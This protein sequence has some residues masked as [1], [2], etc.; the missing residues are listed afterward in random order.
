MKRPVIIGL[1][2]LAVLV[3]ALALNI[4]LNQREE[5]EAA[6][7]SPAV[8]AQPSAP[9]ASAPQAANSQAASPVPTPA[10]PQAPAAV[11]PAPAQQAQATQVPATQVPATQAPAPASQAHASTA[12]NGPAAA[13]AAPEPIRPSFD[14]VRINP[15]GDAVIAG[16]AEPDSQVTV[17]DGGRVVGTVTADRR[18]EW[19]LLPS[20]PLPPGERELSLSSKLDDRDAVASDRVVM[21]VVPAPGDA[22]PQSTPANSPAPPSTGSIALLVPRDQPGQSVL[23]QSPSA[24]TSAGTADKPPTERPAAEKLAPTGSAAAVAID[25]IDYTAEGH[26]VIGGRGEPGALLQAYLDNRGVGS[27]QGNAQG[28]WRLEPESAIAPGNYTLRVDQLDAKGKVTARA[29]IPFQRATIAP[30]IA[31]GR[32]FVVQ[33]GNSLWRIARRTYGK[34]MQFTV[35][36]EANRGQIRDPSLI[37]PGQILTMPEQN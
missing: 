11:Q 30:D 1:I 17:M 26:V 29:E 34:G 31:D 10:A 16:R 36:Y 19:V 6:A 37:Y 18:G 8:V 13:P 22:K 2:G 3:A 28:L 4:R 21:L 24:A 25:I 20:E 14:V 33:P 32:S 27:A 23:L 15:K 35:I 5:R 12:S 7:V 9:Q